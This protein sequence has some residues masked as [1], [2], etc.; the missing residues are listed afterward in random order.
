M[1]IIVII[2]PIYE[3]GHKRHNKAVVGADPPIF[4][5]RSIKSNKSR[6]FGLNQVGQKAISDLPL[7]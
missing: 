1:K 4:Q 3:K 6:R 5:K 2:L 7:H